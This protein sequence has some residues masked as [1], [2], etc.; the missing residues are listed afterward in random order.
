MLFQLSSR[1]FWGF[2]FNADLTPDMTEAHIIDA[3]KNS[4]K[5]FLLT[6]NLQVL[7]EMVDDLPLHVHYNF[8]EVPSSSQRVIYVCDHRHSL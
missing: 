6:G 5:Q 2:Q 7:A 1:L 4:L 3:A 8:S